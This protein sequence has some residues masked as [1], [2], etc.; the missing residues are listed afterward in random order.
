[1]RNNYGANIPVA[2]L[3]IGSGVLKMQVVERSDLE[4]W[5]TLYCSNQDANFPI[6]ATGFS[7]PLCKARR[8]LEDSRLNQQKYL[9]D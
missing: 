6:V 2:I 3:E 7:V 5:D 4:F 1:M 9:R 8:D